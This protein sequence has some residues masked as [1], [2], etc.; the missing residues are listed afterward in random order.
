MALVEIL[1]NRI[2]IWIFDFGDE[3]VFNDFRIE[4]LVS[5]NRIDIFKLN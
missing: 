3:N 2:F 1:Y 4:V 5:F